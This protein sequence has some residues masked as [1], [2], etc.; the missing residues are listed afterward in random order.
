MKVSSFAQLLTTAIIAASSL[1][2]VDGKN[3]I[4]RGEL[5]EMHL[6]PFDANGSEFNKKDLGM[7]KSIKRS[8]KK[9]GKGPKRKKS[10]SKKSAKFGSK[11]K[12][13]SKSGD[14]KK[15]SEEFPIWKKVKKTVDDMMKKGHKKKSKF[16]DRSKKSAKFLKSGSKSKKSKK[17]KLGKGPKKSKQS[18]KIQKVLKKSEDDSYL[19]IVDSTREYIESVDSSSHSSSITAPVSMP[20]TLEDIK[21]SSENM[22]LLSEPIFEDHVYV[23]E[24]EEHFEEVENVIRLAENA[25]DGD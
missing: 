20:A 1:L 16:G 7:P 10:K 19:S 6:S 18:L 3:S 25:G 8:V 2:A 22:I 9:S 5:N 15:R 21:E 12:K 24:K 4:I 11:S 14:D 23:S 13:S 17:L